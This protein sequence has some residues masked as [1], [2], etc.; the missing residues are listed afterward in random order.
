MYQIFLEIF[1]RYHRI[2]NFAQRHD[3]ILIVVPVDGDRRARGNRPR[4]VRGEK[5]EFETVRN[6]IDAIFDSDASHEYLKCWDDVKIGV[7]FRV[8]KLMLKR[9]RFMAAPKLLFIRVAFTHGGFAAGPEWT[10]GRYRSTREGNSSYCAK[11]IAL[12]SLMHAKRRHRF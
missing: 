11:P 6:F 10:S 9:G 4:P 12:L 5:N 3:G 1:W 7:S 2:R 8:C